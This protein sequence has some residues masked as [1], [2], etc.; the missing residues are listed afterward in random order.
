MKSISKMK[1]LALLATLL[2]GTAAHAQ[3]LTPQAGANDLGAIFTNLKSGL[4]SFGSLMEAALYIVGTV[5]SVMF[6]M[7]LYKWNKSDGRDATLSGVGVTL[8]VA[9]LSFTMPML[10]SSSATQ[11]WGQG[12]N[13]RTVEQP[14]F[15]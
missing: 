12:S 6:V 2:I 13:L 1:A 5:F 15:R 4:G 11:V 3:G 7:K 10:M 9:V 14:S 8:L